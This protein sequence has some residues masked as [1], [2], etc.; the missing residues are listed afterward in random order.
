M[1]RVILM[2]SVISMLI[3]SSCGGS[4]VNSGE[5]ADA[6]KAGAGAVTYVL[7]STGSNVEWL[8]KKVTGQHNGTVAIKSG[9]LQVD[10]SKLTAGKFVMD[11]N[12]IIDLDIPAGDEYNAKLVGHL[13]SDEFFASEK[14]PEST[15]ELVKAE[16]I[17][18]A[19]AGAANYTVTGNLTIKGIAK[20]ITFP[21]TITISPEAVSCVAEFEIDR[22][23][24]DIKYGSGKF[25]QDIGDK[26]IY[27]T[28]VVKFNLN[29][30]VKAA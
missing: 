9:E 22:T 11:M 17:A 18:G 28:F 27:D 7:D 14:H 29:A 3:L 1:K 21:A 25:F 23:Q 4:S 10:S 15:F 5:S 20:S 24:W 26:M 8:A 30:K 2:S 6:A 13:K 16:P 19:A 12:S